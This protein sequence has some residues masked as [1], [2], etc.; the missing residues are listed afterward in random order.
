MDYRSLFHLIS[1]RKLTYSADGGAYTMVT[2]TASR[3]FLKG[4]RLQLF[5][6]TNGMHVVSSIVDRDASFDLGSVF[7]PIVWYPFVEGHG[8]MAVTNYGKLGSSLNASLANGCT[9]AISTL[10]A[11]LFPGYA[12]GNLSLSLDGADDYLDVAQPALNGLTQFSLS[13]WIKPADLTSG[14]IQ[15]ICGQ[16]GLIALGLS[17]AAHE[18]QVTT[19]S[20]GSFSVPYPHPINT[21]H[22]LALTGDGAHLRLY[23]DGTLVFTGGAPPSGGTYGANASPFRVGGGSIFD[24]SG[25]FFQG[26]LDDLGVFTKALDASQVANLMLAQLPP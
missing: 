21:W 13:C 15:G 14:G 20:A 4:T 19:V 16:N 18:L 9:E 1:F 17:G 10:T 5:A 3:Y 25:N 6:L 12:V 23:L 8:T 7:E 24:A 22:H 11:P 2:N 26:E